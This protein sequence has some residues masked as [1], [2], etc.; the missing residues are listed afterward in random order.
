M[1]DDDDTDWKISM[2]ENEDPGV[3]SLTFDIEQV[4][5][6]NLLAVLHLHQARGDKTVQTTRVRLPEN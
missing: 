6:N 1:Q 5:L 4:N 3:S 2:N